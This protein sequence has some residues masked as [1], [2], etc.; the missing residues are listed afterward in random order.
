MLGRPSGEKYVLMCRLECKINKRGVQTKFLSFCDNKVQDC[1][2]S[3]LSNEDG[4]TLTPPVGRRQLLILQYVCCRGQSLSHTQ[5][6]GAA[7]VAAA[8][9]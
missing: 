8:V 7:D 3:M 5:R 2:T 6:L 1:L 4:F 9:S